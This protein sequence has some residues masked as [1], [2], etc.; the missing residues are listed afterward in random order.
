MH[1]GAYESLQQVMNHYNNPNNTVDDFFE[2]GGWCS[3][4]Q[5]VGV[6]NCESLYPEAR[7]NSDAV[8]AKV[9]TE[10]NQNDPAALPNTNLNNGERND[11]I[12]FLRTLTDPCVEDRTCLS[13]WLPTSDEAAD[14][15]QLNA[16][17]INGNPL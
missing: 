14:E 11:I 2:D 13:A 15:L 3:L 12:A 17:D 4:Q 9:N 8:L 7:Q 10:R 6:Q 5:F 16:I 1:T